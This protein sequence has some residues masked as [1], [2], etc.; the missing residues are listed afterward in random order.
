[1]AVASQTDIK[2]E[3]VELVANTK[4][5]GGNKEKL[6]SLFLR[7]VNFFLLF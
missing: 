6:K 1:M 3:S 2:V 4:N 5:F 7:K